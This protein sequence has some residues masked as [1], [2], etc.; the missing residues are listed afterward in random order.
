MS[1]LNRTLCD[2]LE[3]MRATYKTR[4]FASLLGLIEE[5]QSMGNSM[6]SKLDSMGDIKRWTRQR[7]ELGREITKLKDEEH[8][9]EDNIEDMK[10]VLKK[11]N[12]ELPTE[13][14]ND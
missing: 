12:E 9:L 11:L 4:N 5:A 2:V 10:I 3:E 1:Y 7:K 14:D 13:D 6:E 8:D